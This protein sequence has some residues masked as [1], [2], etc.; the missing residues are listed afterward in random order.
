MP[1][2]PLTVDADGRYSAYLK[3]ARGQQRLVR[4]TDGIHFAEHG[5]EMVAERILAKLDDLSVKIG[6]QTSSAK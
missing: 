3:D 2:R 5:Y 1:T 6:I 4:D